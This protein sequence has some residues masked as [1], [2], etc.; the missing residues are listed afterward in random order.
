[1]TLDDAAEASEVSKSTISRIESRQTTA[2]IIVVKALLG[3][4]GVAGDRADSLIALAR[5]ANQRGWWEKSD[6]FMREQTGTLIGLEAEASFIREYHPLLVPGLLQTAEYSKVIQSAIMM[7]LNDDEINKRVALRERRQERLAEVDLMAIIPEEVLLRP[8]GGHRAMGAQVT[9]LAEL[10]NCPNIQ[11][12]VLPLE[13]G[14]HGGMEGPFII[15]SFPG[16][17]SD[18]IYLENAASEVI[19]E[20]EQRVA[21]FR[22]VFETL[23]AAALRFDESRR[24]MLQIAKNFVQEGDRP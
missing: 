16:G 22:K 1:M 2:K 23:L 12:A 13:A 20:D 24:R 11:I 4:Y 9:Y 15:L 8:V 5:E 3:A 14:A 17:G 10:S 6:V 21:R 19:E 18:V 7:E